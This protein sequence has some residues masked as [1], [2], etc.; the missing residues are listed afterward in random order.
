MCWIFFDKLLFNQTWSTE[1][2]PLLLLGR[3]PCNIHLAYCGE[4]FVV[5][6]IC[7]YLY[8]YLLKIFKAIVSPEKSIEQCKI[9]NTWKQNLNLNQEKHNL[10]NFVIRYKCSLDN[11][12]T[13]FKLDINYIE[14][15]SKKLLIPTRESLIKDTPVVNIQ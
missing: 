8:Q 2:I 4:I 15:V 6:N 14:C 1:G 7:T 12:G 5:E 10:L 11:F 3:R 9:L 13:P